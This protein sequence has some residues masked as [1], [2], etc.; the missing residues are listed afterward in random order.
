[1]KYIFVSLSKMESF[2]F[3][4]G[5]PGLG[6]LLFPWARSV[7]Y[8]HINKCNRISTT[9]N[10]F[11]I[12]TILRREKD[13]RFYSNLF[14]EK[15][16]ISGFKKFYLLNFS[17]NV[18]IFKG[19]RNLFEP[20]LQHQSIIKKKL[21]S[22]IQKE[23]LMKLKSL[24]KN[25]IGVHIRLGDFTKE[26]NE[27]GLRKG[28]WNLK[29]PIKWYINIINKI[30]QISKLPIYI[31]SDGQDEELIEILKIYNCTRINLGESISDMIALSECKLIISSGSTF[32]M[33]S[34]FIG[35]NP[36]IWFPGQMRQSIILNKSIYEGEL[37]Y[38]D[39]VPKK[40][41]ENLKN[42]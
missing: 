34:S 6:N 40:L 9:W 3:R 14:Y 32:S 12:G 10:T 11:K 35:Q 28:N 1:M 21:I 25:R 19:M 36:T 37:D 17:N 4:I 22:I 24:H 15:N 30:Q 33:W 5:G 39:L 29:I 13:K 41:I 27:E 2:G 18:L 8:E 42:V 20:I 16:T 31:F 7:V 38:S 23:N 26:E